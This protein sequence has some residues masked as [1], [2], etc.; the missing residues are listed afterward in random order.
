MEGGLG[1][2]RADRPLHGGGGGPARAP[3]TAT[4][5]PPPMHRLRVAPRHGQAWRT[6]ARGRAASRVAAGDGRRGG[7]GGATAWTTRLSPFLS[8]RASLSARLRSSSSRTSRF[9]TRQDDGRPVLPRPPPTPAP[10]RPAQGPG[11]GPGPA[12]GGALRPATPERRTL[13]AGT[14]GSGGHVGL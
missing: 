13:P 10:P 4:Q 9:P 11:C 2:T 8:A 12:A 7:A 1:V 14:A 3:R 5:T 6:T